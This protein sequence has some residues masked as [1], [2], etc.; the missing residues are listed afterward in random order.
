M[1]PLGKEIILIVILEAQI[2]LNFYV[3]IILP[4]ARKI[5]YLLA[6]N[7]SAHHYSNHRWHKIPV[8]G[9]VVCNIQ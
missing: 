4:R 6:A 2:I 3:V 7:L 1:N 9:F 5:I 8:Q